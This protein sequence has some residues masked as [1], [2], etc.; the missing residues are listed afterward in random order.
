VQLGAGSGA[1]AS[2]SAPGPNDP[3]KLKPVYIRTKILRNG[4]PAVGVAYKLVLDGGTVLSGSTTGAGL[5]EQPVPATVATAELTLL[6]TGETRV[7]AISPVES[8]DTVLGAQQ[9]LHRVGHY[10][11]ALDG[12]AGPLT[13]HAVAMFQKAQGLTVSGELDAA[14]KAALKSAYG[15]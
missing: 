1:R 14:T 9:R 12:G 13:A 5:V 10:H 15:S 6:D 8:I 11:G 7:F 2:S 3:D 4:K